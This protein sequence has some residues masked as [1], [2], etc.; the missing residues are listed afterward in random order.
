MPLAL[1]ILFG[2]GALLLR[3]G[4]ALQAS[5]SLR[6]KNSAAAVLRITADAAAAV[7]AFWAVGAAILF[8][9]H[10]GWFAIDRRFI[11]QEPAEWA[12]AE[13]FHITICLIGGAVIAGALAE[14]AKFYVSVTASAVLAGLVFPVVGHWIWSTETGSGKPIG[15][16]NKLGFIDFGG[17][18]AIHLSAAVFGTIGVAVVGSRAGKYNKDGS[19]NS[20]PG[21]SLPML[22]IGAMLLLVGWFPY[23]LGCVVAHWS[24]ASQIDEIVLG[25]SATNILLAGMSGVAGGLFYS[26][27]RYRKPDMFFAYSGLLGALVAI[28]PGLVAVTSVGAALIGLVA[29]FIVPMATLTLDMDAR[30]DDPIG[31]I[32]IHGVGAIWGILA[33]AI[34][35]TTDSTFADHLRRLAIQAGGLAIVLVLST[36]IAAALF[37]GLKAITPLRVVEADEFD[38]LDIGE[39]DIN[40]YPDFQQTTIKSY[41]LREA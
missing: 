27:Y 33:T 25:V 6:A 20:I 32:A 26:H 19:S 37:L 21:H 31:L 15:M 16:L 1:L 36:A 5:G 34:L 4:F 35:D 24:V 13:F 12:S 14:R 40:S 41:H 7:L 18:T 2:L 28:S 22:G 38:G 29:G 23:L 39:H 9:H 3:A 17:A 30:L 8:Q 11:F 10:N